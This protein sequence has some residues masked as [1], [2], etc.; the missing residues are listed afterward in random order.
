MYTIPLIC[1]TFTI[2]MM[3][4]AYCFALSEKQEKFSLFVRTVFATV[5]LHTI[6]VIIYAQEKSVSN[7]EA[8][9]QYFDIMTGWA[10]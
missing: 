8:F 3:W 9:K 6:G 5:V 10:L 1:I 4:S 7:D 2:I